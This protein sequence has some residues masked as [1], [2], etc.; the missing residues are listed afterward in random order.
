[1]TICG[2]LLHLPIFGGEFILF[3]QL[4]RALALIVFHVYGGETGGVDENPA[5]MSIPFPHTDMQGC[6]AFFVLQCRIT[7]LQE[8]AEM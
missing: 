6:V 5:A 3:D 7:S 8:N 4:C 2:L 1:M